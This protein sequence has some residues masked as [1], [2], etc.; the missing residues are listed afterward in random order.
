ML[1]SLSRTVRSFSLCGGFLAVLAAPMAVEAQQDGVQQELVGPIVIDSVA[2]KGN[3]RLADLTIISMAS[4]NRG[5]A[6]TIF[7]IQEA[8]KDL[9]ASGEFWDIT[10]H[11]EGNVGDHVTLVWEVEEQD[12][13]RNVVITG[14]ENV[15][16]DDVR[17]T[18][19]IRGGVP[20]SPG[21]VTEAKEFIRSELAA[22]GIPFANIV[23]RN[24]P[25]SNREKEIILY[26][27]VTEG[28]RVTVADVVF[29][30]NELFSDGEIRAAM[31]VK[32]EG[33]WWWRPGSYDGETLDADLEVNLPA[34]Y[35]SRGYLDFEVVRDTLIID[36]VTGKTRVEV[37]VNE[38]PGYHLADFSITGNREFPTSRLESYFEPDETGLFASVLGD[39]ELPVFDSIAFQQATDEVAQLYQNEG[40]LYSQIIPYVNRNPV[41]EGE[42]PTVNV[43]WTIR[44][45]QQAYIARVDIE[46]NEYTYDR[47]IRDKIF[48]LPGDVYSQERVIQSFQSIS[49]LGYFDVPMDVPSIEPNDQG[50][51]NVTFRVTEKPTGAINF[52]TSVGGRYGVAGFVGYD[53]PNLFGKGKSGSARWDFGQFAN[54]QTLTYTDPGIMGSLVSGSLSLFNARD[55]F[56]SFQSGR[57]RRAGGSLR[58]GFPIPG[59]RFTRLFTGYGLSRTEFTLQ[60]ADADRSLFGRPAG[61]Q[62]TISVGMTRSTLNHPLF[63]T[64]GGRQTVNVDFNGGPLGGDGKFIKTTAEGAWWIPVGRAGGD[65]NQP[66]SGLTLALGMTFR[67]GALQGDSEAFPFE[68]FWLG[69]VQFGERLRGYD[70][71]TVTPSGYFPDRSREILDIDRLGTAFFSMTTELALRMGSQLSG[72]VFLD[73]G[74]VW[75]NA[76]EVDPTKLVRGAGIGILLVTPFGPVGLD[77]AYGFDKPEPGW[78]LHFNLGGAGF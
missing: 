46:G 56:I 22:K 5:S 61:T 31:S 30:N 60:G 47:V 67:T 72:S 58:F 45:G 76:S 41:R 48:I 14:L 39:R 69:G 59:A 9:W 20:Y 23:E 37:T 65:P 54:N 16:P 66:G 19:N 25:V 15:D 36:P 27:D 38:G 53:Q 74:N 62:S 29:R 3:V 50:D 7:D 57:R 63:P 4:I 17:D 51:V 33:F 73:A 28:T 49:S 21:R 43:G 1:H 8:T 44:E 68:R 10:V 24:E 71:T 26:L 13:M 12:L 75:R 52:G 77:Y 35:A 70:E 11:I 64:V 18:T 34:F 42:P 40:Y 32:P 6:Y 55:R 2:V 78:Q